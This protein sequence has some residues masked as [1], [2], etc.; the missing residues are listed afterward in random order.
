MASLLLVPKLCLGTHRRQAPLGALER[1]EAE[2][3]DGRSQTELGNEETRELRRRPARAAAGDL[4]PLAVVPDEDDF[5]RAP[6]GDAVPT[7]DRPD[8]PPGMAEP[9]E[10]GR[11]GGSVLGRGGHGAY[12]GRASQAAARYGDRGAA[13]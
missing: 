8:R 2:L 11:P 1:R 10:V 13:R 12:L 7:D 4:P 9:V 5:F 3:R 6:P